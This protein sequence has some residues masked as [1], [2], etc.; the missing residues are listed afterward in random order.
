MTERIQPPQTDDGFS[1]LRADVD[2]LGRSLGDVLKEL[3]GETF[4]NLVE[5]VRALTKA[6]RSKPDDEAQ[7]GELSALLADL[8]TPE[9]ER[10]LRAFAVYFQLINLA[11]E[12][13]RVRVNRLREG[14]ATV[15]APRRES[16]AAA[17]KSLKD[18][19]WSYREVRSF[20]EGL[21]YSADP[22]GAPDRGQT[23][24]R[25][26][27]ARARRFTGALTR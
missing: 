2:F 19:G 1:A 16:V 13:H 23:L 27:Q 14:E 8:P 18:Q 15:D 20:V 26:A 4:F 6:I 21:R 12:I 7:R 3:E 5:R 25:E 11:E 10:L 9:A 24:H 22:D 17:V